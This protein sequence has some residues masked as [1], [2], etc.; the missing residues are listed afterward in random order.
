MAFS[1]LL[2][3]LPLQSCATLST[4]I[5]VNV[6]FVSKNDCLFKTVEINVTP[7]SF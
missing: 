2:K 7:N 4:E 1:I 3:M 6:T 5:A